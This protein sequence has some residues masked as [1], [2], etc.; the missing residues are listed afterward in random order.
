MWKNFIINLLKNKRVNTLILWGLALQAGLCMVLVDPKFFAK[1]LVAVIILLI[2][3]HS[4]CYIPANSFGILVNGGLISNQPYSCGFK[5]KFPTMDIYPIELK[6]KLDDVLVIRRNNG[7][8]KMKFRCFVILDANEAARELE[9]IAAHN[10]LS[11]EQ[12][13]KHYLAAIK[14]EI[15]KHIDTVLPKNLSLLKPLHKYNE[16]IQQ[17]VLEENKYGL[18]RVGVNLLTIRPA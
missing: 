6:Q 14:H 13:K 16:E 15:T 12:A 3:L 18:K 11:F 4:V 17:S 2:L 7:D 5:L 1:E 9:L 10:Q 8:F